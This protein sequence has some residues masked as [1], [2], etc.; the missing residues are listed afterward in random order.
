[1]RVLQVQVLMDELQEPQEVVGDGGVVLAY[2]LF[3]AG[4]V[5]ANSVSLFGSVPAISLLFARTVLA[6]FIICWDSPS[7]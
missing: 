4:T 7:K 6:K 5:P 3:R 1:M 2:C